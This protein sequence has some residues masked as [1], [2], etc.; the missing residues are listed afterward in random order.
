MILRSAF[1]NKVRTKRF[2]GVGGACRREEEVR[3]EKVGLRWWGLGRKT[4]GASGAERVTWDFKEEVCLGWG[5][6]VSEEEEGG[7]VDRS[8]VLR[9][10]NER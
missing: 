5:R 4:V 7:R 1:E 6:G 3:G 2:S 8:S 9:S 10:Q